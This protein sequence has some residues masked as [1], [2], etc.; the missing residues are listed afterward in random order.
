MTDSPRI[1]CYIFLTAPR[2]WTRSARP[3]SSLSLPRRQLLTRVIRLISNLYTH[4]RSRMSPSVMAARG[5]FG[6]TRMI[7]PTHG[8]STW[9]QRT[10]CMI[11]MRL[12]HWLQ[13]CHDAPVH[14][15]YQIAE[16]DILHNFRNAIVRCP[17]VQVWKILSS[18]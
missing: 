6:K 9:R 4:R 11:A 8:T 16:S 3:C 18:D 10:V 5:L 15:G 7:Y 13:V 17:I 14:C 12:V 1:H 2:R